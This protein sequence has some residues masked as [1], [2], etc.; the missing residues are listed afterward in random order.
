MPRNR[1]P[2]GLK[3]L[4]G[5]DRPDRGGPPEV[6]FPV[7][8]ECEPPDWLDGPD[9]VAKW[10]RAVRL[11]LPVRVLTEADLDD[12]GHLCNMHAAL[13]KKYRANVEPQASTYAQY[14]IFSTEFGMTPASRHRVS[15]AAG[16]EK[17]NAFAKLRATP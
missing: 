4:E 8:D 14:R 7:P 13:L 11:L 12:L 2:H 10:N 15:P 6:E 1:K 16:K 9:A 3:V 17:A 5:T